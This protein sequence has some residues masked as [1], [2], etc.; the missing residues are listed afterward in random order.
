MAGNVVWEALHQKR[1]VLCSGMP[2]PGFIYMPTNDYQHHLEVCLRNL[3]YLILQL[4]LRMWE[5]NTG[6]C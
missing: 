5:H 3:K 2:S 1:R 6:S 4:L